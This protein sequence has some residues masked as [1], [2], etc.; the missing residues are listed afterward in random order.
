MNYANW[1][2]RKFYGVVAGVFFCGMVAE[3]I[4]LSA[5]NI[6]P[7]RLAAAPTPTP[8]VKTIMDTSGA[9]KLKGLDDQIIETASQ[10]LNLQT[11]NANLYVQGTSTLDPTVINQAY[12][13]IT[14]N[15]SQMSSLTTQME[16]LGQQRASLLKQLGL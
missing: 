16:Q 7:S 11:Q 12:T 2:T 15:N 9:E 3:G 13:T 5:S 10:A 14:A 6:E 8:V 4:G 1:T